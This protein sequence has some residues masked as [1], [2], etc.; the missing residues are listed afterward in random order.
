[1][2]KERRKKLRAEYNELRRQ[3][4]ADKALADEIGDED[5]D[6]IAM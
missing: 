4:M 1:M 2:E 3:L 5:V 6:K